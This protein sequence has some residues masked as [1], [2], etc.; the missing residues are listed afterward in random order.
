MVCKVQDKTRSM[1]FAV[2]IAGLLFLL[3][4]YV[5]AATLEKLTKLIR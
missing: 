4:P 5:I 3:S 2:S 1:R